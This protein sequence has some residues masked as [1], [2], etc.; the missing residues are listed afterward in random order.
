MTEFEIVSSVMEL[1]TSSEGVTNTSLSPEQVADEI[2]TLR[3]RMAAELDGKSLFRRPY[4]GFTQTIKSLSVLK[5]SNRVSYLDIPRLV[6]QLNGEPACLYIGGK[7]D[8]S[9][10]RLVTGNLENYVHDHIIGKMP[11]AHYQEGRITFRN[12]APQQIKLVAV[13]EDPSDLEIYGD[14]DSETSEYPMPAAMIDSL[15]GKTAE[16]YLRAMY[17]IRP[18]PNTQTDL[19]NAGP[20]SR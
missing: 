19:P 10:Y 12:V 3:V 8:K 14:Y 18:Q 15:I 16:S 9:P 2:D 13:F 17:R 11:I 20:Q 7:D 6:I 4:Q 1:V 5:D